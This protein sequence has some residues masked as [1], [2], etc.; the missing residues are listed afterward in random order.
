MVTT[1]RASQLYYRLAIGEKL[2][3]AEREELEEYAAR[4]K[5]KEEINAEELLKDL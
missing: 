3:P 5:T 1:Q 4:F 2:T